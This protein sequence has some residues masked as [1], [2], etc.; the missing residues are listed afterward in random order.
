MLL[1]ENDDLLIYIFYAYKMFRTKCS[2]L[3]AQNHD[4]TK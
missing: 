4:Y 2:E 3:Y 1:Y